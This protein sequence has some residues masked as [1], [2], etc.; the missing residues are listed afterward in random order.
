MPQITRRVLRPENNKTHLM[1]LHKNIFM[2]MRH[3]SLD[4]MLLF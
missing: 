2:F 4:E 1:H 3:T